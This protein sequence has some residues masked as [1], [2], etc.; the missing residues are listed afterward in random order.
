MGLLAA[1]R[2][3]YSV[4]VFSTNEEILP[5][6][7]CSATAVVVVV[8]AAVVSYGSPGYAASSITHFPGHLART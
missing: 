1:A 4:T 6:S 7:E 8:A 5:R 2:V 3:V